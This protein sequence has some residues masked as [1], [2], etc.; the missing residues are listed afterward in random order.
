VD[1]AEETNGLIPRPVGFPY[2]W[3]DAIR[4]LELAAP[5]ARIVNLETSVTSSDDYWR[6]K[7]INYRMN[8]D[9]IPCITSARIDVC[10][11]A[12][13][14]VLDWGY[15]GLVET[16]RTLDNAH[17]RSAG[18]GKS[19]KEAEVPAVV[20]IDGRVGYWFSP[21]V[22]HRAASLRTG[23]LPRTG[24]SQSSARPVGQNGARHRRQSQRREETGRYCSC[25]D[26][27]G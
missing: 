22:T 10:T 7:G 14:H 3:G 2:I 4:E 19:L 13:N 26:T 27:L 15:D 23:Q 6:G 1:L 16:L 25:F 21:S 20:D 8:P 11:L 9:N 24:R 17:I 12:N 5:D 18:A